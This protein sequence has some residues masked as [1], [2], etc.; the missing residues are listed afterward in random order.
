MEVH[1]HGLTTLQGKHV[2]IAG[3]SELLKLQVTSKVRLEAYSP[4]VS[5]GMCYMLTSLRAMIADFGPPPLRS[6]QDIH[7]SV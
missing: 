3:G 4:S 7:S 1:F 5:F 2:S 6:A